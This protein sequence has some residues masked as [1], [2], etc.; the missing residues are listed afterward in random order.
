MVFTA[1]NRHLAGPAPRAIGLLIAGWR[2]ARSSNAAETC[3]HR[4]QSPRRTCLTDDRAS[5]PYI[6]LPS[7]EVRPQVN[8]VV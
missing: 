2:K 7:R 4:C 8:G 6:G 5:R 1:E 3:G